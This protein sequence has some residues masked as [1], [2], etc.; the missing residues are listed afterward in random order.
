M[1]DSYFPVLVILSLIT[2]NVTLK[3]NGKNNDGPH[4]KH[5]C[6]QVHLSVLKA[7]DRWEEAWT[8]STPLCHLEALGSHPPPRPQLS[9]TTLM[10]I[11]LPLFNLSV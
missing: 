1:N 3:P 4:R 2:S 7:E 5:R 10:H 6:D 11:H 9:L 8:V